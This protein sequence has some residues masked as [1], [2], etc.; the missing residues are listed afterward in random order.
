[1]WQ[2]LF[3]ASIAQGIFFLVLL[4]ISKKYWTSHTKYLIAFLI[5]FLITNLD[6]YFI[7]S[8]NYK[9]F[10]WLF[11][12]SN[13][14][15]LLMG[16]AL[17]LYSRSLLVKDEFTPKDLL[18]AIP[19]VSFFLLSL[20]VFTLSFSEKV[21]FIDAFVSGNLPLRQVDYIFFTIQIVHLCT[22][23]VF[24]ARI[25][26]LHF[27]KDMTGRE[28][29]VRALL[30]FLIGYCL[31]VVALVIAVFSTGKF[32]LT[33][34]YSY[35][36]AC[37]M[38]LYFATGF[39]LLNPNISLEANKK[40]RKPLDNFDID[41]YWQ[42]LLLLMEKDKPFVNANVKLQDVAEMVGLTS[43]QLSQLINERFGK[44]FS[45]FLNHYRVEE[46][47]LRIV[48]PDSDQFTLVGLALEIGFNSKTSFNNTF[49]K[50]TGL[51]PSEYKRTI[52]QSA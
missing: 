49:K 18:H 26:K 37:S 23:L 25:F 36:F 17:Y 52:Q 45:D 39:A 6:Y 7:A 12:I 2:A 48:Q 9:V 34:N 51:T 42:R 32:S 38:L 8:G 24:I 46:F 20:P 3:I 4:R 31:L 43:H 40:S 15:I 35:S 1:M 16:P 28:S 29:W 21:F 14:L 27:G 44:S 30:G 19:Y 10:P 33:A 50:F 22:Y 47:K 13:G 11:G 5:L 41:A